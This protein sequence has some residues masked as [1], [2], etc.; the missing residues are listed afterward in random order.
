[1]TII[2]NYRTKKQNTIKI[3]RRHAA[4]LSVDTAHWR[5]KFIQD[6]LLPGII[7]LTSAEKIKEVQQRG[8][9]YLQLDVGEILKEAQEQNIITISGSSKNWYTYRVTYKNIEISYATLWH[10]IQYALIDAG[11]EHLRRRIYLY[12]VSKPVPKIVI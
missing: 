11:F 1:M 3:S 6:E 10:D 2:L 5:K 4:R 8:N 7:A 9:K 12:D